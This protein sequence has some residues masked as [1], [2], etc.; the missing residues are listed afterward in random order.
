MMMM[1][2]GGPGRAQAQG[3]RR[4]GAPRVR[5]QLWPN[6]KIGKTPLELAGM[7][8]DLLRSEMPWVAASDTALGEAAGHRTAAQLYHATKQAWCVA[9]KQRVSADPASN[10][11]THGTCGFHADWATIMEAAAGVQPTMHA[12]AVAPAA[13]GSAAAGGGGGGGGGGRRARM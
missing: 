7:M 1:R 4:G 6:D 8:V 12:F 11:R 9:C 10:C 13:D 5:M 2:S 3:T